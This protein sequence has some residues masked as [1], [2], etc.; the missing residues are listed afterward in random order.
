M[1]HPKVQHYVPQFLLRAFECEPG[2]EQVHVYDKRASKTFRTSAHNVAG[3]KGFND[4]EFEGLALTF[5]P[6][7]AALEGEM[8]AI[9][10]RVV[11]REQMGFLAPMERETVA[12]FVVVQNMRTRQ[13]MQTVHEGGLTL[14][15]AL[16]EMQPGAATEMGFDPDPEVSRLIA[17]SLLERSADFVPYVLDKA[18]GLY[19]APNDHPFL[20]GDHP[21]VMANNVNKSDVRGTIGLRVRGIEIYLPVSPRY[22]L[23]FICQT[24]RDMTSEAYERSLRVKAAFGLEVPNHDHVGSMRDGLE[25]GFAIPATAENVDYLNSLQIQYAERFVFSSTGDFDMVEDMIA[26]DPEVRHGP[27]METH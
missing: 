12:R 4:F 17:F 9:V 16:D 2:S 7:L 19:E 14:A 20:I 10:S 11:A 26:E 1:N 13:F 25:Y 18:W 15:K 27:R 6:A 22:C 3:E 5:E 24:L 21:V 23:G 8:A